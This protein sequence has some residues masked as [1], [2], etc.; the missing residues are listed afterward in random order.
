MGQIESTT[1][2][3][4]VGMSVEKEEKETNGANANGK[5]S[6]SSGGKENK[7]MMH[8][9]KNR[10]DMLIEGCLLS[11]APNDLWVPD[12]RLKKNSNDVSKDTLDKDIDNKDN[13]ANTSENPKD[14]DNGADVGDV[15]KVVNGNLDGDVLGNKCDVG[16][17]KVKEENVSSEQN[18]NTNNENKLREMDSDD[19]S[20]L[21]K[22]VKVEVKTEVKTENSQDITQ[23]ENVDTKVGNGKKEK[24][25][26]SDII[27][28]MS[29]TDTL[30]DYQKKKLTTFQ[31]FIDQVLDNSLQHVNATMKV[32]KTTNILELCSKSMN[33]D[34]YK[35]VPENN[36]KTESIAKTD[37]VKTENSCGDR[38]QTISNNNENSA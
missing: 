36:A 30:A 8:C 29:K 22:E 5:E 11:K 31:T 26:M 3:E 35:T 10:I 15:D 32:E 28:E 33:P 17:T 34:S 20:A 13:V 12:S 37:I 6:G 9:V 25:K 18:D 7:E 19:K 2:N 23:Q 1:Q 14:A 21:D 24:L 27:S 38:P 4:A 16:D